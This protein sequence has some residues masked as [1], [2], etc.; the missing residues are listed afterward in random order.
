MFFVDVCC[1]WSS[2]EIR[3][4]MILARMPV[5]GALSMLLLDGSRVSEAIDKTS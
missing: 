4:D 2:D 3:R 1:V 5:E